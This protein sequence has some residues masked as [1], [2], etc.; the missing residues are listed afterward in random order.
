MDVQQHR[1][2]S[3][4]AGMTCAQCWCKY[5]KKKEK[6]KG[7]TDTPALLKSKRERGSQPS[8]SRLFLTWCSLMKLHLLQV[9]DEDRQSL[10]DVVYFFLFIHSFHLVCIIII[11]L[12][13]HNS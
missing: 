5:D 2:K 13:Y 11:I 10:T 1:P 8:H 7:T 12:I 3:T 6:D 4:G 9:T